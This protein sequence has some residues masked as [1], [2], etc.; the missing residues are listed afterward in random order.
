MVFPDPGVCITQY[1]NLRCSNAD[2]NTCMAHGATL[3]FQEKSAEGGDSGLPSICW[4]NV[5]EAQCANTDGIW[6]T[7]DTW[8]QTHPNTLP[9]DEAACITQVTNL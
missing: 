5:N 9:P 1:A 6:S 3:C 8:G 4:W 2:N 7:Q